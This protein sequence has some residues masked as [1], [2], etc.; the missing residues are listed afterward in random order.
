VLG[1]GAVVDLG[2]EVGE[3]GQL[4]DRGLAAGGQRLAAER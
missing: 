1:G 2:D 4:V 3:V